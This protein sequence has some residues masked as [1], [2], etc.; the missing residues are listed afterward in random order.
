VE[1]G[2]VMNGN[3]ASIN[4]DICPPSEVVVEKCPMNT[5]QIVE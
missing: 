3:L 1:N 4:Y 2:I 5:I